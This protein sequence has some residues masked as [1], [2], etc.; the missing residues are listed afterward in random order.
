LHIAD[1]FGRILYCVHSTQYIQSH[2]QKAGSNNRKAKKNTIQPSS[3]LIVFTTIIN[4]EDNDILG[5]KGKVARFTVSRRAPVERGQRA[6]ACLSVC[7]CAC[8]CV[9]RPASV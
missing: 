8:V 7:L 1:R 5:M 9:R 6:C 2:S 3:F 4:Y